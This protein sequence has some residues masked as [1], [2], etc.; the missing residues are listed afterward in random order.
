[1]RFLWDNS[2]GPRTQNAYGTGYRAFMTFLCMYGL[3]QVDG[4]IPLTEDILIYFVAHCFKYLNLRYCTIKTYLCGIRHYYLRTSSSILTEPEKLIR[5]KSILQSVKRLHSA[6]TRTRL[7][8][9]FDIL[10][11]M[12]AS[13]KQV[14]AYTIYRL[15]NGLCLYLCLFRVSPMQRIHCADSS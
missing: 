6:P 4:T 5:L 9:T 10:R 11:Q 14:S 2:L 8:V 3:T 13:L 1:M 7:P 12:C 15:I